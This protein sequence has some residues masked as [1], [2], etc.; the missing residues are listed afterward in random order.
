[1]ADRFSV[2]KKYANELAKGAI[3]T[4]DFLRLNEERNQQTVLYILAMAIGVKK[5]IRTPSTT[6]EALV[7][8][9]SFQNTESAMS[10]VYSVAL[11]ELRKEG[12]ENEINDKDVVYGI[13]EEYANTGFSEIQRMIP[14]FSKLDEEKLELLLIEQMDE[15]FDGISSELEREE[16]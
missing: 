4:Y 15:V 7:L 12:R 10:F 6:K 8:E 5:G 11:Q 13:A 2:D 9:Q 16:E 3:K 1:M 14:D